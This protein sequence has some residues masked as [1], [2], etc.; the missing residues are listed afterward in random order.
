MAREWTENQKNAIFANNGSVLVSAAAGSGKTAVLVQKIIELVTSSENP[1]DVDR[2]LVVTFTRSAA[3][4]M[5]ERVLLVLN[6]LLEKDPYN[7]NLLRQKQLLYK[8]NISTIDSFCIEIERE[9]F[10]KLDINKDFK[11]ADDH[12][13]KVLENTAMEST[14]DKFYSENTNEFKNLISSFATFRDDKALKEIIHNIYSFLRSH[15]FPE[16]WLND[17]FQMYDVTKDIADT[18][19]GRAIF[20]YTI[21]AIEYCLRIVNNALSIISDFEILKNT[22]I[23]NAFVSYF[24]F[25]EVLIKYLSE[26]NWDK[27]YNYFDEFPNPK[28]IFPRKFDDELT[29]NQLKNLRDNIKGTIEDIKKLFFW[30][31]QECKEDIAYLAPIIKTLFD[32][33]NYYSAKIMELKNSR[34]ILDFADIEQCMIKLFVEKYDEYHNPVLTDTAKEV[35]KKYDFIMVDECQD[36]NE[37]QDL[38]FRAISKDENNLFM[39]GDVKQ[40]IYGFRQAM[41]EIFLAR[42]NAYELYD[43][44]QDN[45]PSKIILDKNFRSRK[46]IATGIN[47]IFESLMSEEV[48][49]ME[50]SEEEILNPAAAYEDNGEK[51]INLTLIDRD[52]YDIELDPAVL[53]ARYIALKIQQMVMSKYQVTDNGKLRDVQYGDFAVLLRSTSM[54]SDIFVNELVS[55]GVPATSEKKGSFFDAKEIKVMLNFLRV[56]DNPVQDIPLLS[57]MMSPMYGFTADDMAEIKIGKRYKNLYT[58]VSEYA[59]EHK[60]KAKAF[61]QEISDLRT[62]AVTHSVEQL[63]NKIYDIT[64]YPAIISAVESRANAVKNLELLCEYALQYESGGYKGLSSFVHYLD[65]MQECGCDFKAGSLVNSAVT[66][67]VKVMSIHASKGLEFPICFLALTSKEFNKKDL[68]KDVLLHSQLGVGVRKKDRLRRFTTMPRE[69][70]A[71]NLLKNQMS[72][73]LRILYVALTRAKEKIFILNS[74]KKIYNYLEKLSSN[75]SL[76]GKIPPYVVKKANSMGDWIFMCGLTNP[77]NRTLSKMI[78]MN[79]LFLS[80]DV[81]LNNSWEI[82]VVNSNNTYLDGVFSSTTD[83]VFEYTDIYVD[84]PDDDFIE[85]LSKRVNFEY[86]YS[87]VVNL[88]TKVSASEITHQGS[89]KIYSKI[90]EKPKFVSDEIL[91]ATE[92]GTAFHKFLQYCDFH[93]LIDNS[94]EE[95][96]S[97]KNKGYLT[98]KE[99]VSISIDAINKFITSDLGKNIL[100]SKEIFREFRFM[101]YVS[102]DVINHEIDK[103]FSKE[104]ILL[105]GA[106]DLAFEHNGQLVIV[107]YKTDRIKE[108]SQLRETYHKQLELY[109]SAMEKAT[110]Y[111]VSDC[112]IYSL[113]LNKYISV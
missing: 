100:T 33:V 65:K 89:D 29:K 23:E 68:T 78:D 32:C 109:K 13:L 60:G 31:Q 28:L 87:P 105:Q 27:V 20:Q 83:N 35:S 76:T 39:V 15:P 52:T 9:Y 58:A 21:P 98:D 56:L 96:N 86:K 25:I 82:D 88:P 16:K 4:E 6:L 37:V 55:F 57:V 90:L 85:E 11:I 79:P 104:K 91:S 112:I 46:G 43:K 10:Y 53:E 63:I 14:F 18:E 113:Q 75:I 94:I 61:L 93:K 67:T 17:K 62:F 38:I 47:Y 24:Q 108:V 99:A 101:T 66:N 5:K 111:K 1:V 50:Y 48:G 74:Q 45:Y 84:E 81:N 92:K 26:N 73:E 110:D 71:I 22:S 59:N 7:Y 40:S 3:A 70:V 2:L 19:W 36:V 42:K 106:V 72:E 12:Q 69:G 107:D 41:P 77:N 80:D 34:N 44:T 51:C 64:G 102:A 103:E 49:D 95:I 30:N 54:V 8:A 97:L